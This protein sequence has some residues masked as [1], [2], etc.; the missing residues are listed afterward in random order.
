MESRVPA[1]HLMEM[2]DGPTRC[3]V[4]CSDDWSSMIENVTCEEC[5]KPVDVTCTGSVQIK[6]GTSD[7]Q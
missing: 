1:V 5:L 6:M 7:G 3:G 4:S 2:E